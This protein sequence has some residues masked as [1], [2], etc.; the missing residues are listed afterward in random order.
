N[1]QSEEQKVRLDELRDQLTKAHADVARLEE[2]NRQLEEQRKLLD[3]AKTQ[4]GDAFRALSSEALTASNKEFLVLAKQ[5]L[6]AVVSETKGDIGKR[7]EAIDGLIKPLQES[8]KR[9]Q[10]QVT[11][12]EQKREKAYGSL[13]QQLSTVATTQQQLQS[14]TR[15]LVTALRRP[16]VR[17]RWG[18][19]TLK[20]VVEIS[21]MAEHCD[22]DL[23]V[24]VDTEEGRLRPDLTVNL[25]NN[26]TIVVDAKATFDAYMDAIEAPDEESRKQALLRHA[27]HVRSQ[28]RELSV[29]AY[30][31]QF[32]RTPDFVVLFL[33]GESLFSAAVEQ[34]RDLTERA[35]QS[36][37]LL[38]TPT[39]LI[40]LLK[41]VALSWREEQIIEN[42]E[43]IARVSREFCDRVTTF[44][45]H[46]GKVRQGLNSTTKAFNAA[47]SSWESRV[48]PSG[49]RVE[50][51]GGTTPGKEVPDLGPVETTLRELPSGD[52]DGPEPEAEVPD[53]Q[54]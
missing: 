11:G 31:D 29:K 7:Q 35:I 54:A 1:R 14:E 12:L 10:E 39:T 26:R 41:T 17:G 6:G 20:R 21:G 33:P 4:L 37:V 50:E 46:L 48:L 19:I 18:E 27:Q 2:A 52:A 9:Y 13:E 22:F 32:E 38:A 30:W 8:L 47:V 49:R 53:T 45:E 34:D 24:S 16:E 51:L 42:A 36:K 40:A 5:T 28:I 23:Q 44:A 25:P 3:D 15:N 43:E